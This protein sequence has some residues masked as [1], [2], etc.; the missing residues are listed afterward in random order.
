MA[1]TLAVVR[2]L[3]ILSMWVSPQAAWA[4]SEHR[5]WDPRAS[6]PKNMVGA[7]DVVR[8][9]PRKHRDSIAAVFCG[10]GH[11]QGLPTFKEKGTNAHLL[12][13]KRYIAAIFGIYNV[14]H[15][16]TCFFVYCLS[17]EH[18]DLVLLPVVSS[19]SRKCLANSRCSIYV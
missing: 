7:H 15:M 14:L 5:G 16:S 18:R 17:L 3:L 13:M 8:T 19:A 2:D 10:S 9:Q 4:S 11:H 12:S 1:D 6:L